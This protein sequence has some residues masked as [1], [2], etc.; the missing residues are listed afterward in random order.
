MSARPGK[1]MDVPAGCHQTKRSALYAA[2]NVTI[3]TYGPRWFDTPTAQCYYS[4]IMNAVDTFAHTY[5]YLGGG[6][7]PIPAR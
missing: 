1:P 4:A 2:G 6:Y 3:E 7:A 5:S